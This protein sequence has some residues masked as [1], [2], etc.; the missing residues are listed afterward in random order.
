MGNKGFR[1]TVLLYIGSALSRDCMVHEQWRVM[2]LPSSCRLFLTHRL[3]VKNTVCQGA[4]SL[5]NAGLSSCKRHTTHQPLGVLWQQRQRWDSQGRRRSRFCRDAVCGTE[6]S[7]TE[8]TGSRRG[9]SLWSV[10]GEH[11]ITGSDPTPNTPVLS[12]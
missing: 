11:G 5:C 10:L 2:A 8:N 3:C 1:A 7:R 4:R 12:Q 9:F 6:Q